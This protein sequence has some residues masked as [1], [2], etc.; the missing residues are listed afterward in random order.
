VLF[1]PMFF[2]VVRKIFKGRKHHPEA[3][4]HGASTAPAVEGKQP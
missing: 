2:V 3:P 4:A 1:V